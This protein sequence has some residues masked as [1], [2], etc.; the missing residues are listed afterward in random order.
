M[1]KTL[2]VLGMILTLF[3]LGF[4]QQEENKG[5]VV[6]KAGTEFTVLLKKSM[7]TTKSKV[8]E[9]VSFVMVES[10]NGENMAFAKDTPVEGRIVRVQKFAPETPS[11]IS[12]FFDFIRNED[13]FLMLKAEVISIEDN[14][15]KIEL[16]TSPTF[17]G[18]TVL[19]VKDKDFQLNDGT[20]MRVKVLSD[21]TD[22]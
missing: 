12:L 18:G 21:V 1:R 16:S 2:L 7:D 4:A 14:Q 15:N 19:S 9:D 6:L 20:V 11:Q 17:E 5:K 3:S 10:V 13:K 8:G 22:N